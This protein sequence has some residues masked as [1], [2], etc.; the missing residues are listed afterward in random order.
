VTADGFVDVSEL[1]FLVVEDHGFQ[2]WVMGNLL[3]TLGAKYVVSAAD[4]QAA[5]DI[6]R[7]HPQP[8]DI[9]V[10]DLDMP[11]MDGMAFIRHVGEIVSGVSLIVASSLDRAV[12][13]SVGTMAKAYG[14]NL[15]GAIDKPP[16]AKKL[17]G[18][19][20]LYRRPGGEAQRGAAATA[21]SFT[22]EEIL[23][24]LTREEFEPFFQPKMDMRT[25]EV[26]SAEAMAR[27]RHPSKGTVG[28]QAF[29]GL[30]EQHGEIERLTAMMLKK[31]A[32]S[33]RLWQNAGYDVSV[34]IN[35]SLDS[36]ADVGLADRMMQVVYSQGLEPRHLVFEV[37]QT[38]MAADPGKALEN[39]SRLRMKGFGLS[40]DDYGS[41][42]SSMQQLTRIPFTEL[43]IDPSFVRNAATQPACRAMLESSLEMAAKLNI[44]AVAEG[45]ES[46]AQWDL[47]RELGCHF[48]Q[49]H[50]IARP[51]E[52]GEFVE[53][54]RIKRIGMS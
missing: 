25:R 39:F 37:T 43:K 20:D 41:G 44:D 45:V 7:N 30:L 21:Q 11:G 26:K 51:M 47:L 33:C 50:Y 52:T 2:R 27:W 6:F 31:A 14:M 42:Y 9:I 19:I 10:S 22:L 4:G 48:A 40:I 34:S 5:L 3:Q 46:Q 29:V 28:P 54:L 35:L 49:G 17:R 23:Q 13:A 8:I 36:L 32:A 16:T 1:R 38:A 18:L 24:G 15:L 53:W 12:V